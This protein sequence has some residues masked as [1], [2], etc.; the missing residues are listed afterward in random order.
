MG[1]RLFRVCSGNRDAGR[2]IAAP[3]CIL[4]REAIRRCT[5][6]AALWPGCGWRPQQDSNLR[7]RLRRG[8]LYTAATW[9]DVSFRPH[10]VAYRGRRRSVPDQGRLRA[11]SALCQVM[12][13]HLASDDG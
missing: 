4:V 13:N 2:H 11:R 7:T 1:S 12:V 8:L 9:Q 5:R 6:S 3:G 10:L